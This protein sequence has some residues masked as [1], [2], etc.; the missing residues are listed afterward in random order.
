MGTLKQKALQ[1]RAIIEQA[2]QGVDDESALSS[3]DLFPAWNSAGVSYTA[4]YKVSY[5]GTLYKVLQ[6]HTSQED[7]TPDAAVSLFTRVDNPAEEYPEWVQPTGAQDAYAKDAKVT[8]NGNHWQSTCD[9]NV[10]TPG[11]YGWTEVA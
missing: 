11:V 5:N 6:A 8:Y 9:N 4:G 7:W 10:W 3:I 1:Y 2:M